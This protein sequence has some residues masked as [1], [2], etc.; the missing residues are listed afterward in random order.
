MPAVVAVVGHANTGKTTLI[1][2]LI[3]SLTSRGY[4]IAAVKHAAHGYEVDSEGKDSWQFFRAGANRVVVIGPDSLT[5]HARHDREPALAEIT[6]SLDNVDLILAEG[7]KTQAGPK[8]E[9]IRQGY[10]E[11]RLCLG[12]DL[13]A[14]V[15]DISAEDTVPCFKP[16]QVEPLADFIAK[17]YLSGERSAT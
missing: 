14:V 5:V 16:D 17:R 10:S 7:F 2:K 8:I 3:S 12:S 13:A 15:S 1:A 4:R 6:G 9:I 11:G